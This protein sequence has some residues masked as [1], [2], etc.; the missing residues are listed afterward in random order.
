MNGGKHV[1]HDHDPELVE[2]ANH[3]DSAMQGLGTTILSKYHVELSPLE[4]TLLLLAKRLMRK[5]YLLDIQAFYAQ[6]FKEVKN[7]SPDAIRAAMD[8]LIAKRI[9][10]ERRA[11]TRE[12]VLENSMRNKIYDLICR[13][14]GAHFSRIRSYCNSDSRTVSLHLE[15]LQLF[16]FIRP[17]TINSNKVYFKKD[18]DRNLDLLHYYLSKDTYGLILKNIYIYPEISTSDLATLLGEVID[19]QVLTRK[20]KVLTD[21]ELLACEMERNQIIAASI[22][23]RLLIPVKH[24]LAKNKE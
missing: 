12:M 8:G 1:A 16:E 24:Y 11:L 4:I 13:K 23:Q 17:A 10:F 2:E 22:P 20:L 14:P 7:A 9:V 19:R 21:A 5:H 18:A 15:M 6:A 3:D